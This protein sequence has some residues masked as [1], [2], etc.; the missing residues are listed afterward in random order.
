MENNIV[1]AEVEQAA[2]PKKNVKKIV[3]ISAVALVLVAAVVLGSVF[4]VI[5]S[6][7][8]NK[9]VGLIEDGEYK[10]AYRILS[11]LDFKD[12]EDL[13][14]N[15]VVRYESCKQYYT[16]GEEVDEYSRTYEFEYDEEGNILFEKCYSEDRDYVWSTDE[17]KYDKNGNLIEK[18]SVDE[19]DKL[20]YFYEYDEAGNN[21]VIRRISDYGNMDKTILE[22]DEEG[23]LITEKSYDVGEVEPKSTKYYEYNNKGQLITTIENYSSGQTYTYTY[24]YN[25]NGELI[26]KEEYYQ[27]GDAVRIYTT[28]KYNKNGVLVLEEVFDGVTDFK[29]ESTKYDDFGNILS[30]TEYDDGGGDDYTREYEYEGP[31]YF[32]I[33]K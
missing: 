32:Y 22:Y 27:G 28:Y 14:K 12:S 8:Y 3:I 24:D 7:K 11:K 26:R 19:G 17:Y 4:F 2:A 33:E 18:I 31:I 21:I 10:E 16:E 1:N 30:F 6:I 20:S 5:P 15:F 25:K 9:A 29:W 13:L 23:K